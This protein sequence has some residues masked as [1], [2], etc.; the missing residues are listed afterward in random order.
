VRSALNGLSDRL[1]FPNA[2]TPDRILR[3]L[4]AH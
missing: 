1:L 3:E 2:C 4:G